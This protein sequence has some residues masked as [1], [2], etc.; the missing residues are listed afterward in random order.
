MTKF[1]REPPP[2]LESVKDL[3]P[4]GKRRVA[5]GV[6]VSFNGRAY[7]RY[8]FREKTSEV[9]EP[10]LTLTE[11]LAL[12]REQF[13]AEAAAAESIRLPEGMPHPQDWP[14]HARAWLH[15]AS[16]NNDQ[17][18]EL[19]AV[20]SPYMHRVVLPLSLLNGTAAWIARSTSGHGGRR[21]RTK[22]LFPIGMRKDLGAIYWPKGAYYDRVVLTEDPLSAFRVSQASSLTVGL[23]VLG[24]SLGRDAIV[25]LA[26]WHSEEGVELVTWLDGDVY[27]Q[28]G[29]RRIRQDLEQLGVPT[30]NIVTERDPK[31]YSDGEIRAILGDAQWTS[32]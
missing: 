30:Q 5:D 31:L 16:I 28:R 21:L 25:E 24:T 6:L 9:Y 4:G 2:W 32:H 8:D 1:F 17:L 27:G 7:H 10:Q 3:Q 20:W 12:Q 19:G 13:R 26:R 11:R 22:Y 14:D 29:A 18:V 23:A 15:A